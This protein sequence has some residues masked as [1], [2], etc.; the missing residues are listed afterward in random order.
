MSSRT[1]DSLT[2]DTGMAATPTVVVCLGDSI[3]RGVGGFD[4]I[5]ELQARPRNHRFDLRNFGVDGDPT[6][7]AL[8]RLPSVIE[9]DPDVVIVALGSNDIMCLVLE[10]VRRLLTAQ[11]RLPRDPSPEWFEENL[12][13]IVSQLSEKTKA[14]IALVSA[15]PM[16]EAPNSAD[17]VQH[18][19]NLRFA[20]YAEKTR[21]LASRY[22]AA[23]LPLYET[24]RDLIADHPGKAATGLSFSHYYVNLFR[25][26]ALG[27]ELDEIGER[28]GWRYH[29]D[30]IH[31]N[32]RGGMLLAELVQDYLDAE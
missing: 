9:A 17:P 28:N 8:Q 1:S 3:T 5:T 7:S 14:K 27:R 24:M 31:L 4:W 22:D 23:Y 16:G 2:Q 21:A 19:L 13:T 10:N 32:R 25:Q 30:G 29:V 20:E 12:E 15:A 6:Y 18:E 11:K 26:H